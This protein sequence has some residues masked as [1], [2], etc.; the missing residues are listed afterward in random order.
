MTILIAEFQLI[1]MRND[2]ILYPNS[3]HQQFLISITFLHNIC[4]YIY[5]YVFHVI[6]NYRQ[7][8]SAYILS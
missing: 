3:I 7:Q 4:I 1:F 2:I 6:P 8:I 5:V